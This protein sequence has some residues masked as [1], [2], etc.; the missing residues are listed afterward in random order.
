MKLFKNQIFR[1]R[2]RQEGFNDVVVMTIIGGIVGA[3]FITGVFVWKEIDK[4]NTL[5]DLYSNLSR[6]VKFEHKPIIGNI[7]LRVKAPFSEANLLIQGNQVI[8]SAESNILDDGIR[9]E[10]GRDVDSTDYEIL[11]NV[12]NSNHFWDLKDNYIDN[13]LMDGTYY[14]ISVTTCGNHICGM[15]EKPSIKAV[16]CYGFCPVEF[17]NILKSIEDLWGG[18]IVE[19]GV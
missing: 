12:I 8:Y 4:Q 3:L 7:S 13:N 1:L 10:I 18:D 17:N 5:N 19:I 6:D 9:K 14:T 2:S 16:M 15:T 11:I